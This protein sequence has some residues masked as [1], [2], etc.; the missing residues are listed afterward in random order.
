MRRAVIAAA[1]LALIACA[2]RAQAP[3]APELVTPPPATP[4]PA[5]PTPAPP[6]AAAAAA[7]PPSISTP[8]PPISI[9]PP[10]SPDQC[11]AAGLADLVG[12]PRT[13]IPV[14]V[15]PSRRRV[16]CSTC[17]RTE[18]LRPDRLTIE[19]DAA[20]GKVTKLGCN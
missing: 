17:P 14:P 7:P 16:V 18:D 1:V 5:T 10:P 15:D 9:A 4:P 3:A 19:Y 2:S 6:P 13:E 11:G 8:A 12:K 20:T